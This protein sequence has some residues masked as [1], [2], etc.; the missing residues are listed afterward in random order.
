M[1]VYDES[2]R[3]AIDSVAAAQAYVALGPVAT[4]TNIIGT[5]TNGYD[6]VTARLASVTISNGQTSCAPQILHTSVD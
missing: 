6:G 1:Y 2:G 4:G 3:R 5:F